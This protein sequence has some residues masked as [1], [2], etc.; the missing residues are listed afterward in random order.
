MA[1]PAAVAKAAGAP[2]V[3]GEEH[4]ELAVRAGH[5]LGLVAENLP[6]DVLQ[7]RIKPESRGINR[8]QHRIAKTPISIKISMGTKLA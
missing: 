8:A 2:E 6:C 5:H 7:T 1:W 4:D 3:G